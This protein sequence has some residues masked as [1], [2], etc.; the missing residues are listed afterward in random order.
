MTLA[1]SAPD[2]GEERVIVEASAGVEVLYPPAEKAPQR[3]PT[4]GVAVSGQVSRDSGFKAMFGLGLDHVVNG[5]LGDPEGAQTPTQGRYQ[6]TTPSRYRGQ[7]FRVTTTARF[8]IEND[9]AFGYAG[10]A[11]GYALRHA[12][13]SCAGACTS[14]RAVDHGLNLGILLGAMLT[15]TKLGLIVGAEVGLD[16]AWFPKGHPLLAAWNQG[17]S[18]RVIGGWRF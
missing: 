16:W 7:L 5:W 9:L 8:G 15:P 14:T 12:R 13:L 17:M 3:H 2:V 6:G 18:A 10:V 11:P 4:W 1:L